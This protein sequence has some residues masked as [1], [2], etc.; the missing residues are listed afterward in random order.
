VVEMPVYLSISPL[1]CVGCKIC[2]LAC[3]AENL[4]VY[5]PTSSAIKVVRLGEGDYVTACRNCAKAPCIDVCPTDALY[6][7]NGVVQLSREKCIGC[8]LCIVA[9]PFGAVAYYNGKAFKCDL[10]GVCIEKCPVQKLKVTD[11]WDQRKTKLWNTMIEIAGDI[12][13]GV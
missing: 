1:E 6:R 11:S 12:Q 9:C 7:E 4:G 10:C 8:G 3:T 13:L 2:M 5:K